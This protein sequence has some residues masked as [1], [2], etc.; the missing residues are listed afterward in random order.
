MFFNNPVLNKLSGKF[1]RME[2]SLMY[3]DSNYWCIF[4]H[5][6]FILSSFLPLKYFQVDLS[7]LYWTYISLH[8]LIEAVL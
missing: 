8:L 5:K 4:A 3:A 2:Y 1:G 7:T 6:P